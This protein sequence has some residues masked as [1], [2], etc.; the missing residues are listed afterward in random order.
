[1]LSSLVSICIHITIHSF[2]LFSLSTHCFPPKL[3]PAFFSNQ[4]N[5]FVNLLLC[6]FDFFVFHNLKF[7]RLETSFHPALSGELKVIHFLC[8]VL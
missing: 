4:E 7:Y 1:D 2:H 6:P 3:T 5:H 8:S